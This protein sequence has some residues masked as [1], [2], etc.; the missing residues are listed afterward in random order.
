MLFY[1]GVKL[2]TKGKKFYPVFQGSRDRHHYGDL[3]ISKNS[4]FSRIFFFLFSRAPHKKFAS[5]HP[6]KREDNI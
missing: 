2:S 1:G 6:A 4:K 3:K 5:A